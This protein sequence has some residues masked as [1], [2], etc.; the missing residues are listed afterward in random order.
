MRVLLVC[1]APDH[2]DAGLVAQLA[3]G[4]DMVVAVDGGGALCL[5]AG[6]VP[7]LVLGDFDS[8]SGEDLRTLKQRGVEIVSYDPLKDETDLGLALE[9]VRARGATSVTVTAAFSGRL[10]HSLAAAGLLLQ[11]IDLSPV[12]Q[13]PRL[14]GWLM[15]PDARCSLE[16][17]GRGATFS[18]IA[19]AQGSRVDLVGAR[20][21]GPSIELRLLDSRG[22]S[23]L[24]DADSMQVTTTLGAVLVLSPADEMGRMAEAR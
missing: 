23:N 22:V 14:R 6:V 3:Q 15:A 9:T 19:L 17:H 20:W 2:D 5:R 16:L 13:E 8:L 1:A 21:S 7:D 4:H 18:V 24:I 10:D 12:I 11:A